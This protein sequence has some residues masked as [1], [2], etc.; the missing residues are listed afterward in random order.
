MR[1][2]RFIVTGLI[3]LAL[4]AAVV[5]TALGLMAPWV[6]ELEMI[7]H[8]RPFIVLVAVALVA[9]ALI[10]RSRP[11]VV[12]TGALALFSL[13]LG[14]APLLHAATSA[15]ESRPFLRLVTWNVN[16][17]NQR[18]TDITA[19]LGATDA[20]VIVLQEVHCRSAGQLIGPL[21][22]L[23][24]HR[25]GAPHSCVGQALLSKE[26]LTDIRRLADHLGNTMMLSGKIRRDGVDVEIGGLHLAFP[27]W[28]DR[29]V[30]HMDTLIAELNGRPGPRIIAG[31]FNLT[32]FSWK[33]T[34]LAH[35]TGLRRH[36]T[37]LA[38]WPSDFAWPAFQIDNVM[39]SPDFASAGVRVG[40]DLGS[41]HRPV[42]ADI[43]RAK[44]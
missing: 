29:Q 31:D 19:F 41:D 37:F 40:P 10:L 42:I 44:K 16:W 6:A 9:T 18:F 27:L 43:T 33:L 13:V 23:Y 35:A 22:A 36:G 30:V 8:F 25:F 5:G 32:P 3:W 14:G 1:G 21:Q 17:E 34:K 24:P 28:P 2:I 20:D 15:S 26:P 38:S 12:G 11:L 39:A 7:N 4:A